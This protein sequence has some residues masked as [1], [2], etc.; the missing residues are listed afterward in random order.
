VKP[1]K[2][3]IPPEIVEISRGPDTILHEHDEQT[4][5]ELV[6]PLTAVMRSRA[7]HYCGFQLNKTKITK[8]SRFY[9]EKLFTKLRD[10]YNIYSS[11]SSFFVLLA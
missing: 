5:T 7:L 6:I 9:R 3:R 1:L 10:F 11:T 4:Q 2:F 8:R